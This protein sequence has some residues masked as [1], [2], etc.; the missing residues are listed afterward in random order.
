ME[1]LAKEEKIELLGLARRMIVRGV[2]EGVWKLETSVNPHLQQPA[3]GFVTLELGG[4]LRGC[5]GQVRA[6][7]PL[8]EVVQEMAHAA[9]TR[10]PRFSP[11]GPEELSQLEIEISVLSPLWPVDDIHKIQV[12]RD[13]LMISAGDQSGLLLPQVASEYGWDAETFLSHTCMKAGLPKD[14]WRLGT[15]KI[16]AFTA[17]IFSEKAF[18]SE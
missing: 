11:L 4:Q 3:G 1:A 16:E 6:Q 18:V 13:G 7:G 5:I 9:A 8:A 17:Q 2:G 14:H 12:G 15:A 10:D